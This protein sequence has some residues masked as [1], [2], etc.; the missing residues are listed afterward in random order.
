M[1]LRNAAIVGFCAGM[2]MSL[3][4]CATL[5]KSECETVN[6]QALGLQDGQNGRPATW[7]AKHQE[8]CSQYKLPVNQSEWQVGWE[9]G[10][11]N[12]CTPDNGLRTGEAGQD[13]TASCP[14]DLAQAF[15]YYNGLGRRVYDARTTRDNY[16]N[17]VSSLEAQIDQEKDREK[18][19]ELEGRLDDAERALRRA[20]RDLRYT[21]DDVDRLTYDLR[22]APPQ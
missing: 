7:I 19:R 13:N 22:A 18:R 5:S 14:P 4:S 10:I 8:A 11:R 15:G 20:E 16:A 21:Q 12:Y 3:S 1:S 9:Q 17:D 2:V 6:W